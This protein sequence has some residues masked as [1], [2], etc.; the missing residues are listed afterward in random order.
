MQCKRQ[1]PEFSPLVCRPPPAKC[2][3][4]G[5]PPSPS[6][7]CHLPTH[8]YVNQQNSTACCQLSTC[9]MC[10]RQL[11]RCRVRG[12]YSGRSRS[13]EFQQISAERCLD[14]RRTGHL[15]LSHSLWSFR[16]RSSDHLVCT[17][18]SFHYNITLSCQALLTIR[19]RASRLLLNWLIDWLIEE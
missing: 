1:N 4:G 2:R 17:R 7:Q 14:C 15:R 13:V 19:S 3:R 11:V 18:S 16:V 8:A 12:G 6:R 5:R 10:R 9:I